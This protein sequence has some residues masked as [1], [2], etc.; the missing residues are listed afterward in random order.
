MSA[1]RVA[2]F[3][4]VLFGVLGAAV[5]L[6]TLAVRRPAAT[7]PAATVLV[8]DVPVSLEEAQPPSGGSLVDL[9]RQEHPTVWMLAHGIREA[10]S[11][12]RVQALVL[13]ID[14]VDWGWAKVSEIREAVLDFRRAGKPVYAALAGGGERE[15]LLASAAG[16]VASPPLAMLQLDGLT[17]SALFMR[18]TLDKI[19]VTPN[20]AQS[21][22]FKSAVEGWTQGSM[23]PPA[24]E[25]LQALVDDQF[26]LLVDSLSSARGIPGDSIVRLLDAGPFGAREAFARGLLDTVLHR[27]ELDSMVTLAG[28]GRRSTLSLRRYVARLDPPRGGRRIALVTAVGTIAEGRSRSGPGEGQVLGAETL[29]KALREVRNRPSIEAVVLRIDSPGG[30]AQASDEIWQEVKRCAER[31]PVIASFSDLAASGGYY[32]AVPADSIVSDAATL[33]GSIG[34]FGGKLNLLGLYRKLGLNVETVS[35]GRHAEMFSS[36]R[37]FSPEESER[38][39]AQMDEVYRVFL[40]RVSEGRGRPESE[41]DSVG[42]GRVWTGLSA[43]RHGLVDALGGLP[44]ALAM[45]RARAGIEDDESLTIEVYPR[46]QRPLFQRLFAEMV[47][48]EEALAAAV[49]PPVVRAWLAAATFPSGAALTLLPWS[50]EVR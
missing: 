47:A 4:V 2:L 35:R 30:S 28:D 33:T 38:F 41:I 22:R 37:D 3:L 29:I 1:R 42:Q 7:T 13:H 43:R 39:Q 17:A 20:F 16:T 24:R 48:D 9:L 46:V 6:A 23:S 18:G 5:L 32:I 45:A 8:F 50:I 40:S 26:G 11:D 49:L 25:A 34:A 21:G 36:F 27:S 12:A 19:G 14:Q 10:A 31:K 44:S 15:Y